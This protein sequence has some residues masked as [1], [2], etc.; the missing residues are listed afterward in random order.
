M[1]NGFNLGKKLITKKAAGT[2]A[3]KAFLR[4]KKYVFVISGDHQ[5]T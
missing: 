2:V 3:N 4:L 5:G 1:V